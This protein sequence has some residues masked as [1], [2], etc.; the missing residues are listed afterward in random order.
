[1]KLEKIIQYLNQIKV[2]FDL[3]GDADRE[4]TG[5]SSLYHYKA[6]TFAWA[7]D[8]VTFQ[9]RPENTQ[10]IELLITSYDN[11]GLDGCQVKIMTADPRGVFFALIDHF[12]GVPVENGISPH[13]IIDPQAVIGENVTIGAGSVIS[14]GTRIGAGTV[15]GCHVVT[16]GR[17]EIGVD[18]QIQSGVVIGEDGMALVKDDGN[19]R[20]IRHYGGVVV[21]DRVYIGANTCICRGTI[22]DTI[23]EDDAK[24]DKL[25]HIAHNCMLGARTLLMAGTVLLSSVEVGHDTRIYSALI[26]EQR[27]VGDN[28]LIAH[29]TVV[30]QKLE[31]D[32]FAQGNPMT[33]VKRK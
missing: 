1:M 8:L 25:C 11:P 10:S 2:S 22:E 23:L 32:V 17:V 9:G 31:D 26:K 12:W 19:R 6:N 27:D 14:A 29:G 13:A 16:L 5:Y 20:P 28:V 15:L 21:G 18:C 30:T 24:I 33:V 7:R 3:I 4:I